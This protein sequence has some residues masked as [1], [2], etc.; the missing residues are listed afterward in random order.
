M[1]QDP[2]TALCQG[3][4]L[5]A[6]QLISPFLF[7]DFVKAKRGIWKLSWVPPDRRNYRAINYQE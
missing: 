5:F 6:I 4:I 3:S 7:F 2:P 1:H